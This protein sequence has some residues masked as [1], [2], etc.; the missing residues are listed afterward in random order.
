MLLLLIELFV[1]SEGVPLEV[2]HV[3]IDIDHF[4]ALL[5]DL[6]VE[7]FEKTGKVGV[8]L[9]DQILVLLVVP[10]DVGE[11]LFEML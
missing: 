9:A 6:T 8:L 10:T 2:S 1:F 5:L 4:V 11:K 7:V 3:L